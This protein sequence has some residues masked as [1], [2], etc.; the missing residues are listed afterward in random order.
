MILYSYNWHQVCIILVQEVC[1][2]IKYKGDEFEL[3][4]DYNGVDSYFSSGYNLTTDAELTDTE[5]D[6]LTYELQD[7]ICN[8]VMERYGYWED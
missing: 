3:E 8:A 6:T 1:V 5:L 7:D 4:L 2:I